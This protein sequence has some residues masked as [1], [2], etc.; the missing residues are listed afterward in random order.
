MLVQNLVGVVSAFAF[1]ACLGLLILSY[2]VKHDPYS[3]VWVSFPSW[4]LI[5]IMLVSV[6][7]FAKF[8]AP[9]SLNWS[10]K[11]YILLM[12]GYVICLVAASCF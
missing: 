10:K 7:V 8:S 4:F 5:T 6:L 11:H 9:K 3:K 12:G 2:S 1:S